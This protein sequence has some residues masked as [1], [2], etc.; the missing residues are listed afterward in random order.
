M[1]GILAFPSPLFVTQFCNFTARAVSQNPPR[2]PYS[3]SERTRSDT[4]RSRLKSSPRLLFSARGTRTRHASRLSRIGE[5]IGEP[6]LSSRYPLADPERGEC[7]RES[8]ATKRDPF[9]PSPRPSAGLSDYAGP[10]RTF[11]LARRRGVNKDET[12]IYGEPVSLSRAAFGQE[13]RPR[14]ERNGG[15]NRGFTM[16]FL[17]ESLCRGMRER[18]YLSETRGAPTLALEDPLAVAR[19]WTRSR[20]ARARWICG[21]PAEN[22]RD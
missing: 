9:L 15:S 14:E 3:A 5:R 22:P 2:R 8:R 4:P 17:Y 10:L 19:W 16:D 11:T 20:S 21:D 13:K 6:L 18:I 1:R 7:E 12:P